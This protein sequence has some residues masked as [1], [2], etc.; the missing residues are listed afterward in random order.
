M[1]YVSNSHNKL[2]I[3]SLED[4]FEDFEI[5]KE[6]LI[7]DD[8]D[9]DIDRVDNEADFVNALL[10][11]KY[12][13][14]L[15]DFTLPGY[16]AF[17]ALEKAVEMVPNTPFIVVSGSIG[18]EVAIELIKKGAIDYVLKEKLD[19]LPYSVKRALQEA[20]EI[21]E[22][23]IKEKALR[24]SER[25]INTLLNNLDGI[26]Y[27]CKN[28]KYW[29]MV[30]VSDSFQK[31][32]G[33]PSADV[34]NN[35]KI[36]YNDIVVT[37]DRTRNWRLL[38]NALE[39]K[40]RFEI[41]Y[42]IKTYSG[43]II[44]VLDKG[45]GI[46]D[47]NGEVIAIEGFVTDVTRQVKATYALRDSEELNRSIM[48]SA[49]DAIISIDS[50]G[51]ILLWNKAAES[52]F[53]YNTSDMLGNNLYKI[54]P[55]KYRASHNA[56]I[57]KLFKSSNLIWDDRTI[58][59][60]AKRKDNTTF[61]VELS[62]SSWNDEKQSYFTGIIRDISERKF[63]EEKISKLS[64][65][66]EQSPSVI[67]ITDLN[68]DIEYVNPKFSKLTGY[69]SEDIIGKN[70]RI[71]KS[72]LNTESFYRNLWTVIISG[73][74]WQGEFHNK[75][76]NGEM[77]WEHAVI[78]PIITKGEIINYIKVSEDITE[79]KKAEMIKQVLYNIA[80]SAILSK[81]LENLMVS[82]RAELGNIIDTTNF[83]V[84]LYDAKTD[85]FS[86]PYYVDE[87]DKF[88]FS[89][90]RKTLTRYVINTGKALLARSDDVDRL[91]EE[92]LVD[93]IGSKA[94][95]WLGIPLKTENR[96]TGVFVL[97]SYTNKD[98]YSIADMEMLEFASGQ[99]SMSINLK[100]A[101]AKILH[102]LEKATESD[103]LKTA[104]LHNISHEIRTPMNGI[105][106]FAN[107]LNEPDLSGDAQ[108]SY[109]DVI[110]TSGSRM[111]NTLNDLVDISMLETGQVD[112]KLISTNINYEI[113]LLYQ[114][115]IPE[116]T[117]AGLTLSYNSE[118]SEED[119]LVITDRDKLYAILINLIKNAIKYSHEGE[120]VYSCKK[121]G[122]NLEFKVS[123]TGIGI[124]KHRISAIFDRF[125]Q[126]DI[127]DSKAYEGSGLGLSISQAYVSMLE[128]DINV[129]SKE[130]VGSTFTF[131]IPYVPQQSEVYDDSAIKE[132]IIIT[133]RKILIA[134]DEIISDQYLSIIL[135]EDKN[136]L[137][138]AQ[139][140][141]E[142]VEI[143]KNNRDIELILMD[144]RMPLKG[145]YEATKEIRKLSK[146][147]IIIAQTAFARSGDQQKAIAAGCDDYITK[148]INADELKHKIIN[149]LK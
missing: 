39:N 118:L 15:S 114:F 58:E 33:Y 147:V 30:F 57:K 84:A 77:F 112:L 52:I 146:D 40:S 37:E 74:E 111:L 42:R 91:M 1:E 28:D 25:K 137:F 9:F 85:L 87:K 130:G 90:K 108:K 120:I 38:Q 68:G 109:I 14:I 110:M 72:N 56:S 19:R 113:K 6:L 12:N 107:L 148:P 53:G 8:F 139:N 75:K 16:D 2:K 13:V 65:A 45:I 121:I 44:S 61:P 131:T 144:I 149:Y 10:M 62:L 141:Y 17:M 79:S 83:F 129:I 78:S 98:A 95:V 7:K 22:H 24:E 80:N 43:D 134:E 69:S 47:E 93:L 76:K 51:I 116:A 123:D 11:Q 92:G 50:K 34:V 48:Q 117:K 64:T 82:I 115:F 104:F 124:P 3:L 36:A 133:N 67:V 32:T 63:A 18:E 103:K 46:Y 122:G 94:K 105:M 73:E 106:G 86:Y 127:T 135:G 41:N 102:A 128:G 138:H 4:S 126:A 70:S 143:F 26:V 89:R 21:K 100:T 59:I 97:Q 132:E 54:I 71:L 27:R 99:I 66:V 35:N 31:I 20:E 125:V 60:S 136:T 96:V 23:K 119:S 88:S 29:T 49:A 101:E 81:D 145:G 140:G 5:I 55:E 142:A